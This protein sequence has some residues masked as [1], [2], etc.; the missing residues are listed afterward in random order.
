MHI[1]EQRWTRGALLVD[2]RCVRKWR[3]REMRASWFTNPW[4]AAVLAWRAGSLIF[5]AL[6]GDS[7]GAATGIA[8]H[9]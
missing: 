2:G 5:I 8:K 1:D 3:K 9:S 4:E 7:P 6:V